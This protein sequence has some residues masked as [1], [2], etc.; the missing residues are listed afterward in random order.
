MPPPLERRASLPGVTD[1][2][3]TVYPAPATACAVAIVAPF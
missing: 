2:A 1:A 3:A